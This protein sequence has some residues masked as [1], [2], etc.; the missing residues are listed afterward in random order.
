MTDSPETKTADMTPEAL[1]AK[2]MRD[3]WSDELE[4]TEAPEAITAALRTAGL[5]VSGAPSEEQI[6]QA[7][8][9]FFR[10]YHGQDIWNELQDD[11]ELDTRSRALAATRAALAAGV[12]P[13][14]PVDR[15]ELEDRV[16]DTLAYYQCR[17]TNPKADHPRMGY[18][19]FSEDQREHLKAQKA[20]AAAEIVRMMLAASVVPTHDEG[21]RK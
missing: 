18:H 4:Y 2:A 16:A 1:V 17:E 20:E 13:P 21:E 19:A 11:G 6:E 9:A 14:A 8:R 15:E 10:E 12:T 7:A 3:S 5:L